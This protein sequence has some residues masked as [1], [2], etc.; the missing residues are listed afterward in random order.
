MIG[1]I[2]T[3]D[4]SIEVEIVGGYC[5]R[6]VAEYLVQEHRVYVEDRSRGRARREIDIDGVLR[7]HVDSECLFKSCEVRA[8][9][10]AWDVASLAATDVRRSGTLRFS[11]GSANRCITASVDVLTTADRSRISVRVAAVPPTERIVVGESVDLLVAGRHFAGVSVKLR[12]S[13]RERFAALSF[14]EVERDWQLLRDAPRIVSE[15]P[16]LAD[17]VMNFVGEV[18]DAIDAFLAGARLSL[19]RRRRINKRV[20]ELTAAADAAEARD[21]WLE[22]EARAQ[23]VIAKLA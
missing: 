14:A 12:Q 21:A 3:R 16:E 8:H 18:G 22:I 11:H 10:A 17:P 6:T 13:K 5:G 23:A 2:S 19:R 4:D 1:D 15:A 20:D 9:R 7:I